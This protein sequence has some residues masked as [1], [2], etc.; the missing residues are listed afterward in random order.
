MQFPRIVDYLSK[1]YETDFGKDPDISQMVVAVNDQTI[2]ADQEYDIVQ[3]EFGDLRPIDEAVQED[4]SLY[5]EELYMNDLFQLPFDRICLS[6]KYRDINFGICCVITEENILSWVAGLDHLSPDSSTMSFVMTGFSAVSEGKADKKL[7]PVGFIIASSAPDMTC[8]PSSK[9]SR[10]TALFVQNMIL[11]LVS[12]LDAKGIETQIEKLPEKLIN[13]RR[14]QGKRTISEFRHV[15]IRVGR[16]LYLMNGQS[17]SNHSSPRLHWRR[18]HTRTLASGV[19]TKVR[20]HLVG[21][22]SDGTAVPSPG[23]YEVMPPKRLLKKN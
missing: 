8:D 15:K 17:S 16:E 18:G 3:F 9:L 12:L 14:K 21:F 11:C 19:I 6:G 7:V 10:N 4:L 2:G 13:N 20:C 1:L 5:G 23:E 22:L